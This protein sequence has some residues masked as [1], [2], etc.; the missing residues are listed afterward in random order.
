M[1]LLIWMNLLV[2][3]SPYISITEPLLSHFIP[4]QESR[5]GSVPAFI[6]MF[7]PEAP[8]DVYSRFTTH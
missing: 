4:A 5:Q 2:S 3:Q 6:Q 7:D 8:P 1:I